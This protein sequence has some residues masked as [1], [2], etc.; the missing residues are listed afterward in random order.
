[1]ADIKYSR[2]GGFKFNNLTIDNTGDI[3]LLD[4][5]RNATPNE[6]EY[7]QINLLVGIYAKTVQERRIKQRELLTLFVN[8]EGKLSFND[9]PT[10]FYF[11]ELNGE[12]TVNE[13]VMYTEI[14]IPMRCSQYLYEF[15]GDIS[16]YTVYNIDKDINA[17]NE[18]INRSMWNITSNTSKVLTNNGNAK[19]K[20]V[21]SIN[22]I[23]TKIVFN[24]RNESFTLTGVNNEFIELD[25]EKMIVYTVIEGKKVSRL[26]K[27]RGQFPLIPVGES[28]V[29]I[30][31]DNMNFSLSIDFRSTYIV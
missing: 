28:T 7:R 30:S 18:S 3:V 15:V 14:L 10:L 2:V 17:L 22:G 4:V 12:V 27:F 1:M 9:E 19:A 8:E 6:E 23:A 13:G 16:D 24:F 26:E 25:S 29:M 20:P 21:I 11:A 5:A 31:G